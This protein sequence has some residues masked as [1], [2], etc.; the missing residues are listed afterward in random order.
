MPRQPRLDAPGVLQHVMARGIERRKIFWNDKDR[1][2]FLNRL[3]LILEET[4][5]QCYAWV[6]IPNHFHLLLRTGATPL[7]TVM[8]RLMTGYAV[9]F[10]IRHRRSGHLFQNRYKSVVCEEDPYLLELI[11]YIHLNPLRTGLVKDLKELDKYS[12]TGHSA[13]LGRR[14][15]SLIPN[16]PNKQEKPDQP[17]IPEKSLAEKTVEDVLRY[18]GESLK[19]ARRRYR[20]F[21]KNGIEQGKRPEFQGGGLVRPACHASFGSI[22]RERGKGTSGQECRWQ[23]SGPPRAKERSAREGR[24]EDTG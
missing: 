7:S 18:F 2:S 22:S 20:Q 13:I 15:N 3:A 19:V 23:Q 14:K 10:N 4:Q 11:R 21:V 12:W 1:S 6:L 8:R 24:C 17:D 5:T 16:K 9:T